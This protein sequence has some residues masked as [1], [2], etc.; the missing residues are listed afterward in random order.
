MICQMCGAKPGT[1][2][3]DERLKIVKGRCLQCALGLLGLGLEA[4][5]YLWTR[6][7][8]VE[9]DAIENYVKARLVGIDQIGGATY[10]D[11]E[12]LQAVRCVL[13]D[14]GWEF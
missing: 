3:D 7:A 10:T 2:D 5:V 4:V 11:Q 6:D 8:D 13:K 9:L 1:P 14:L 12:R